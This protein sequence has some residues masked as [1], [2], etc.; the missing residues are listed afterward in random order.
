MNIDRRLICSILFV[1]LGMAVSAFGAW[2]DTNSI[3]R[4]YDVLVLKGQQLPSFLGIP[5]D[6]IRVYRYNTSSG[7]WETMPFQVDEMDADSTYFGTKNGV[8]DPYDEIVFMARD[9]GDSTNQASWTDDAASREQMRYRISAADP[10]NPGQ[11]GW[12]YVYRSSSLP[13]VGETYVQYFP[14]V[15]R[16]ETDIYEI[17]HGTTGLQEDL[18]LKTSAGGDGIDILDRQKL[19]LTIQVDLGIFGDRTFIFKEEQDRRVNLILGVSARL[20]VRKDEVDVTSAGPVRFHRK[21]VLEV[22]ADGPGFDETEYLPFVTTFYADFTVFKTGGVELPRISAGGITAETKNFRLSTDFNVDATGM[23]MYNPNNDAKLINGLFNPIDDALE[24][25][26]QNW[27]LH[28][29][30]PSRSTVLENASLVTLLEFKGDPLGDEQELYFMDDGDTDGGDTGDKKSYGDTGVLVTGDNI[31]GFIDYYSAVYYI[32]ANLDTGQA[33]DIFRKHFNP[34]TV[35]SQDENLQYELVVTIDPAEGGYVE[36]Q[37]E[38][39]LYDPGT[40]V[41]LTAVANPGFVFA[42][43]SEDL[44]DSLNPAGLSMDG[45]K[46]VTAHFT[47]LHDI[48]ITTDPVGLEIIVDDVVYESPE[49]FTW[50]E[51]ST[52]RIEVDSIQNGETNMRYTYMLWSDGGARAHDYRV[53]GGDETVTAQF[54]TQ[55]WLELSE[56][57]EEGGEVIPAPPGLWAAEGT[58]AVVRAVP[59]GYYAFL[60]WSG[61]IWSTANPDSIL[62][63]APKTVIGQFGNHPPVLAM[64]DTSFTEDD[65]LTILIA[66]IR[67][68]AEDENHPDSLLT[69]ASMSG[70]I[71]E[72]VIDDDREVLNIFSTQRDW[73]GVDTVTV[74]V[75]DPMQGSGE[76]RVVVTVNPVPDPPD[77]FELIDPPDGTIIAAWPNSLSF[78][79]ERAI[80][81]D[82]GDVPAYTFELD[83][84]DRFNSGRG[85]RIDTLK[86][87][88]LDLAWPDSLGDGRYVW[89]VKAVDRDGLTTL[90]DGVYSLELQTGLEANPD[91]PIP[92]A[93]VLEQNF[94]NPFNPETV[95][96]Y[97]V[98]EACRVT[99]HVFDLLGRE[100]TILVDGPHQPGWYDVV[101]RPEGMAAGMYVYRIQMGDFSAVRKML[102]LE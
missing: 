83:T 18:A 66:D 84:T 11:R 7:A 93:F 69:F 17:T 46:R 51:G 5:V 94:P 89:R 80:D 12:A 62:M 39:P 44:E 29:V 41:L 95:I 86:T 16:V 67:G 38:G 24:W 31:T 33:K 60:Q 72:A 34:L 88:E 55:Y 81:P 6:Q 49:T 96:R 35:E 63:D 13:V 3:E 90:S 20:R 70:N 52:H 97:G 54:G 19:R 15:D 50:E 57:P 61:D 26:G 14:T 23:R 21:M 58:Y 65:T 85:I 76:D 48:T 68:W 98:K 87:N 73:N 30:D 32:P 43:W 47:P 53:P 37:P 91:R 74:T 77:D 102:L 101:F 36:N 22:H 42:G 82:E 64:P 8:F 28:S 4:E 2:F 45:P 71:L 27:I 79:W 1:W 25:P 92:D 78:S 56:N 75:T 99:L 59:D 100:M 40:D 9:M 10:L